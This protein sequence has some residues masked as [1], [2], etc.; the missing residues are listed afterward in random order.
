M[1][2]IM[3]DTEK[4]TKWIYTPSKIERHNLAIQ[5]VNWIEI[6]R[7]TNKLNKITKIVK[8]LNKFISINNMQKIYGWYRSNTCVNVHIAL[9]SA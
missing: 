2:D 5:Y 1:T 8:V 7:A 6:F 9:P 4:P 3:H